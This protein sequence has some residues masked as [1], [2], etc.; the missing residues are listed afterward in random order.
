MAF[1]LTHPISTIRGSAIR[2]AAGRLRT[3]RTVTPQQRANRYVSRMPTAVITAS[4]GGHPSP[5]A[6]DR[7]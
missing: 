7:W 2:R 1:V 3:R 4:L 6:C 5:S